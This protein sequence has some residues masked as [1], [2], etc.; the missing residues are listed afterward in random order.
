MKIIF[1]MITV[2]ILVYLTST[3]ALTGEEILK[4]MDFNRDYKTMKCNALMEIHID[5][6]IRTKSMSIKGMLEGKKSL[7]EFLNPEDKGTKYLMLDDNLWIYFPE[8]ED[9]VK[10]SGHM[11]KEGMMGSDV[12]YED[13]LEN[14]LLSEK[15]DITITGEEKFSDKDCYVITLEAKVKD[16]PYHKRIMYVDKVDFVGLKEEM[17]AKSGKLLKESVVLEI[18]EITGRKYPVK[19]EMVNKLRKNSKTVFTM[20]DLKFDV[21]FEKDIFTMR[22]LRK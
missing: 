11:L 21:V 20:S 6:K 2:I 1:K 8:E 9:V 16:A 19:S 15:Y 5:D 13:A 17:Y 10:I 14:D 12:S 3:F 4:K 22:N 7:V 18:A